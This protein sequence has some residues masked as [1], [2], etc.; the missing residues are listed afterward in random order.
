MTSEK[1]SGYTQWRSTLGESFILPDYLAEKEGIVE[2][3]ISSVAGLVVGAVATKVLTGVASSAG[4][5]VWAAAKEVVKGGLFVQE[6]VS[7]MFS[8]GGSYFSDLVAEAKAE[9]AATPT[10]ETMPAKAKA[11]H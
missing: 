8:G 9:L 10:G 11:T 7:D 3:I 4:T 1:N 2:I 5:V 6:T